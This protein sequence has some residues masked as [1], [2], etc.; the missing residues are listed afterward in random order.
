MLVQLKCIKDEYLETIVGEYDLR[1]DDQGQ[2]WQYYIDKELVEPMVAQQ[3]ETSSTTS[4]QK[5]EK[6]DGQHSD[7]SET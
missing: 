7:I 4:V 2:M 6:T 1:E 3:Q 5:M